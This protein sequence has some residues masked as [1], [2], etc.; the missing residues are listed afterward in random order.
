MTPLSLPFGIFALSFLASSLFPISG[1]VSVPGVLDVR[2]NSQALAATSS[3]TLGPVSQLYIADNFIA[4][5][6][7]NR[8]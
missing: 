4:P 7:Y 8:S 1:A 6:G 2:T 5:D 3:S